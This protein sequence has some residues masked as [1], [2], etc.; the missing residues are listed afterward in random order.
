VV[1]KVWERLSVNEK[2]KS[3]IWKDLISRKLTMWKLAVSG[4]NLKQVAALGNLNDNINI[5]RGWE[6][7][8]KNI[9]LQQKTV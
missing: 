7:I 5:S 2:H 1:T 6:N 3:L 8:R 4:L 9:K